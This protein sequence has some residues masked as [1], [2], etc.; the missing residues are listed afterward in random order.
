LELAATN[1]NVKRIATKEMKAQKSN[2]N[3]LFENETTA[4]VH[5]RTIARI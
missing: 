4:F 1:E 3:C 5:G 2:C